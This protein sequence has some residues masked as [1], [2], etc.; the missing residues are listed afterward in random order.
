MVIIMNKINEYLL[1]G[2]R[3]EGG[4]EAR[5]GR[6]RSLNVDT[7]SLMG[8]CISIHRMQSVDGNNDGGFRR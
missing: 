5:R 4:G 6:E 3:G 7:L 8:E 1:L 2:R